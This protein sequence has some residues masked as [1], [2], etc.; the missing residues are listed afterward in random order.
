MWLYTS[1]IQFLYN[2]SLCIWWSCTAT[3]ICFALQAYHNF[4]I[5][6]YKWFSILEASPI[7]VLHWFL[8]LTVSQYATQTSCT[9]C[10]T[11]GSDCHD[12]HFLG[13]I[14]TVCNLII[15][16]LRNVVVML[17]LCLSICSKDIHGNGDKAPHILSTKIK[18]GK[19]KSLPLPGIQIQSSS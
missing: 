15:S 17:P 19:R 9:L 3:Q 10:E 12:G 1:F 5:F 6:T 2:Y 8:S 18:V 13:F 7:W 4:L 11:W 16:L 14:P